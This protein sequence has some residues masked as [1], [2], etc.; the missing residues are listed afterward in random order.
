MFG[1]SLGRGGWAGVESRVCTGILRSLGFRA[2]RGPA[3]RRDWKLVHLTFEES[4]G[5][6]ALLQSQ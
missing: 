1:E 2:A 5:E 4:E 6:A 3:P